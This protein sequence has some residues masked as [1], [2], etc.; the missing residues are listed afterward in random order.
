MLIFGLTLGIIGKVLLG[1]AV[2]RVHWH[3]ASEHKIDGD[4]V[5][6][7]KKERWVAGCAIIFMIAGYILEVIHWG[8]NIGV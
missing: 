1:I 6:A 2:V 4:V 7:I 5:R 8:F 3:I